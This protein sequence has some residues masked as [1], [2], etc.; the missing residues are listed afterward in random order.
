MLL[1]QGTHIIGASMVKIDGSNKADLPVMDGEMAKDML[2]EVAKQALNG[3]RGTGCFVPIFLLK[4]DRSVQQI[5][6]T[7]SRPECIKQWD[8][9]CVS[10]ET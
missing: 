6:V 7:I 2:I 3:T 8:R 5:T 4:T 9:C 10:N 1:K